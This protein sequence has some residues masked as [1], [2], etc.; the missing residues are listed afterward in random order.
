MFL[1]FTFYVLQTV[2]KKKK[3]TP[4]NSNLIA[5]NRKAKH[6]FHLLEI[7]EAGMVLTG[8]EIKSARARQVSLQRSYVQIRE[9]ELWLV[10]AN[11][12]VYEHGNRENHEPD[13]PRK[14]L[15]HKKEIRKI[16]QEMQIKGV[17]LIPTRMYLKNGRAK[18]GFAIAKGKKLYDKREDLKQK[19][20]NRQMERAIRSKYL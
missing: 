17:T 18:L 8:T 1:R 20:A 16:I 5:Q 10:G 19:D 4:D 11:I 12:A 2:A 14:L 6:D 9:G 13:R 3:K 15:L 7:F